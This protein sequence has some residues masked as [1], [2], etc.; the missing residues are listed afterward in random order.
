MRQPYAMRTLVHQITQERGEF[1]YEL[2]DLDG[3]NVYRTIA[4][5]E[6][7]S[8]WLKP[9]IEVVASKDKRIEKVSGE[10][11]I[12]VTFVSDMRADTRDDFLLAEV[13]KILDGGTETSSVRTEPDWDERRKELNKIKVAALREQ[14]G[15]EEGVLSKKFIIDAIIHDEKAAIG[16][17]TG[18]VDDA[19]QV[20]GGTP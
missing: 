9:I 12:A 6:K 11:Y 16:T 3:L 5:D 14:Y 17:T 4:F 7:T 1:D 19:E 8:K 15:Y 18:V 10:K 20:D 13:E 2:D